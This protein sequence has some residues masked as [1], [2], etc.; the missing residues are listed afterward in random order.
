M[1]LSSDASIAD[2]YVSAQVLLLSVLALLKSTNTDTGHEC[3]AL[4]RRQR[5]TRRRALVVLLLLPSLVSVSICTF[6][7]VKQVNSSRSC[8]DSDMR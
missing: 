3:V 8:A 1:Y 2:V 7:L 4:F 5:H 6:V